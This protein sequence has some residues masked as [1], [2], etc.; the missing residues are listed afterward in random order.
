MKNILWVRDVEEFFFCPMVFYFSVALGM[1]R[2]VGLWAELGK[3]IQKSVESR[4]ECKFEVFAREFEA[5]SERLRVKGRIDFV[6]RAEDELVPLE[7]KYSSSVKPWWRYSL[8]LY[9]LLLEESLKKP[10][11]F[12]YL[13]LTES[14]KIVKVDMTDGDRAFVE[15]AVSECHEILRGKIPKPSKSKSCKNCDFN[16]ICGE[17]S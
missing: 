11:K 8:V 4:I 7:I 6:V 10:V 17:F 14:D 15:R 5:E 12:G 1:G 13:Y 3:E 2:K 16:D 9:T